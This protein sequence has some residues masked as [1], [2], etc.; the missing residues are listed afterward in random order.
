[1]TDLVRQPILRIDGAAKA[2]SGRR[3]IAPMSLEIHEGERVAVL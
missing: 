3:A 1:M 2:Y